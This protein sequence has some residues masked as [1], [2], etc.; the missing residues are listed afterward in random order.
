[1]FILGSALICLVVVPI[2]DRSALATLRDQGN[3]VFFGIPLQQSGRSDQC[4]QRG[5]L[6]P[7]RRRM[8]TAALPVSSVGYQLA[9]V[10]GMCRE[11]FPSCAAPMAPGL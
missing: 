2:D 10:N 9:T 4:L 7:L 5:T 6:W 1:M 3:C 8:Q 11:H